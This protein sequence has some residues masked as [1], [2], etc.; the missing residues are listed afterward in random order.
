MSHWTIEFNSKARKDFKKLD[1]Q[2]AQAIEKY[3]DNRVLS[4]S[5]PKDLGK[6]LALNYKGLWRYRVD[7]FR[8]ICRIEDHKLVVLVVKI[9][10]RDEV[11]EE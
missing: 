11:Y 7:K 6:P 9:G 1:K 3:L 2:S 5:H 4:A 10:S 8:I